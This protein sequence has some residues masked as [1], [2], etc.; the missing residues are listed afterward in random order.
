[1]AANVQTTKVEEYERIGP[2]WNALSEPQRLAQLRQLRISG[3]ARSWNQLTT[4]ERQKIY[5]AWRKWGA[6]CE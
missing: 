1:M 2:E 6:R 3:K 4:E 5:N